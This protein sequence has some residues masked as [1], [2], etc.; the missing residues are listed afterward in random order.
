MIVDCICIIARDLR[1]RC[2]VAILIMLSHMILE[3]IFMIQD[4]CTILYVIRCNDYVR[5]RSCDSTTYDKH[6]SY[7]FTY[8]DM[9]HMVSRLNIKQHTYIIV[10]LFV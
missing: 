5:M 9:P 2:R 6:I 4:I 10:Q 7:F 1:M 8:D 3:H